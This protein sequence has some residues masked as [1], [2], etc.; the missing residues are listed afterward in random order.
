MSNNGKLLSREKEFQFLP[1]NAI[2]HTHKTKRNH[3]FRFG[4]GI[5]IHRRQIVSEPKKMRW[6]CWVLYQFVNENLFHSSLDAIRS[7]CHMFGLVWFSVS[8]VLRNAFDAIDI[9]FSSASKLYRFCLRF[10]WSLLDCSSNY[11]RFSCE[12]VF[13][14]AFFP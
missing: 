13:V 1:V 2:I 8:L 3:P 9:E 14:C 7:I 12:F 10:T 6:V 5:A 11:V 4:I